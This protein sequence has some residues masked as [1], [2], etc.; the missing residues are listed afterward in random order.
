[1]RIPPILVLSLSLTACHAEAQAPAAPRQGSMSGPS[2]ESDPQIVT[3]LLQLMAVKD[4]TRPTNQ[5]WNNTELKYLKGLGTPRG[6]Q[7]RNR[8]SLLGIPLSEALV[9]ADDPRLRE[10][11]LELARWD[12][13]PE[14]RA[15]ALLSLARRRETEQW[16]VFDE[17]LVNADPGIRFAGLEALEMWASGVPANEAHAK[18]MI[19]RIL[20]TDVQ[21][22][23]RTYA[24]Q[25]LLRR[26]DVIGRETLLGMLDSGDWLARA[27][28][29]RY[30]GELGD[31][32]DYDRLLD[33]MMRE[34][35]NDFVIAE[36]AIACLKLFPKKKPA[37]P[38][39]P[40]PGQAVSAPEGDELEPLVITAPRLRIPA[41]ALID[42]RINATL[43]R[44]LE[45]RAGARQTGEQ[46]LDPSVKTLASLVSPVGLQL[47]TRYTELGFLLT[48]GLAGVSDLTLRNRLINVARSSTDPR[49]RAAALLAVAYSSDPVDRGL[50][51][52][53][54]QSQDFTVRLGAVE[55][56]QIWGRPGGA[57]DIGTVARMD[58]SNFL[59]VYA[60]GTALRAG[61][62]SA[63]DVII[64]FWQ[65]PDWV[66]RSLAIRYMGEMGVVEDYPRI[67]F[68]LQREQN[69]WVK[70]EMAG[71]LLRLHRLRKVR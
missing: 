19:E 14:I 31:G 51:Q 33:R 29:A 59:R 38:A 64:R 35:T 47:N 42:G 6:F 68:E 20:R 61:D 43:L 11:M 57:Q 12:R 18:K 70:A 56:L 52:E 60:A 37:S 8:Y 36:H 9:G 58:L 46:L 66:V 34:Q 67:L 28:A 40:P 44:L 21:P 17:A 23:I 27:A 69:N 10:Q 24:A 4:N 16:R 26:G 62:P 25:A 55:A 22:I 5:D 49:I 7:L 13:K 3:T 53:A 71:A 15:V 32:Q 41:T 65:D 2:M 39:A 48:E 1:M 50:F 54:L 45:T 63:R 30:L